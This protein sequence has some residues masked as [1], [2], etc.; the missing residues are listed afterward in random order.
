MTREKALK[1]SRALDAIEMFE[2]FADELEH[3]LDI[4]GADVPNFDNFRYSLGLLVQDELFRR[5]T[6]LEEL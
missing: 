6:A 4:N 3:F 1:V 5:K 2:A